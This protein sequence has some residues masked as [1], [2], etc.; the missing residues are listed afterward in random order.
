MI[1]VI[2]K[3][4]V[5][6]DKVDEFLKHALR[7]VEESRK[8]KINISYNLTRDVMEDNI[9][10]FIEVWE[11]PKA[12]KEHMDTKHFKEV[13]GAVDSLKNSLEIKTLEEVTL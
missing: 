8:E 10:T 12:L 11:S 13:I 9:F 4:D 5:K 1:S 3:F 7:L 2:A 6:K